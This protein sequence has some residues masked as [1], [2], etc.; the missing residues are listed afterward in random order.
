M[1]DRPDKD[2]IEDENASSWRYIGVLVFFPLLASAFWWEVS[3][4]ETY[5]DLP[6]RVRE[7][8]AGA[9]ML[10]ALFGGTTVWIG[11]KLAQNRAKF[12]A[13]FFDYLAVVVLLGSLAA[14]SV[15][16]GVAAMKAAEILE[17]EQ[18]VP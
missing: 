10:C 7:W 8:P 1:L 4:W 13:R 15:A 3:T 14:I 5:A 11:V 6:R 18:A 12:D 9:W 2:L 16:T 17:A